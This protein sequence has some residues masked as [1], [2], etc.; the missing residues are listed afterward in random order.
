MADAP[1]VVDEQ[2][3][4]LAEVHD[5]TNEPAATVISQQT[6][7]PEPELNSS[8]NWTRLIPLAFGLLFS[9]F[10]MQGNSGYALNSNTTGI[11]S[12]I[13][14]MQNALWILIVPNISEAGSPA[15]VPTL[16]KVFSERKVAFWAVMLMASGFFMSFLSRWGYSL[17][18]LSISQGIAGLGSAALAMIITLIVRSLV[19]DHKN[20]G[21]L[22]SMVEAAGIGGKF[23]GSGGGVWLV[24]SLQ[25]SSWMSEHTW[26][27]S[28]QIPFLLVTVLTFSLLWVLLP[29][30]T[31]LGRVE[32]RISGATPHLTTSVVLRLFCIAICAL[33][34]LLVLKLSSRFGCTPLV[35]TPI[36]L[37][38][39]L[40]TLTVYIETFRT[41]NPIF[42]SQSA[43]R[44]PVLLAL[45]TRFVAIVTVSQ[46]SL[47]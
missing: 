25:H 39:L 6:P 35:V 5:E 17:V 4:L 33:L 42:S 32:T 15:A 21:L 10:L 47:P 16:L 26:L 8:Q 13:G 11:G 3:P 2:S 9:K 36:V 1:L 12:D 7:Q 30:I 20:F 24:G 31:D 44:K 22:D 41:K 43:L 18:E 34:I 45:C 28:W 46:V 19:K 27:K 40:I 23:G 29:F 14:E 38:I 37:A